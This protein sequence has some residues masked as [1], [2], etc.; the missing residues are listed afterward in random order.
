[1]EEYPMLVDPL[2]TD[3]W[4]L[5][6]D[7]VASIPTLWLECQWG[8]VG[9]MESG[10]QQQLQCVRVRNGWMC[11][12]VYVECVPVPIVITCSDLSSPTYGD[13]DYGG[14]STNSRPVDTVA[15]YT[16]NTGYTLIGGST[17]TCGSD[18]V[19]SGFPPF[20]QRKWNGLC[21]VCLL[22][23][24]SPI[25]VSALTYPH[26][27]MGWLCTVMDPLTTDLS[28]LELPTAATLATLS[29]EVPPGSVGL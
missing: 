23:V 26:W 25:Q 4:V 15:T 2:T 20:C 10:A 27:P 3:Q 12:N 5:Q 17:R 8:L 9:V 14:G 6:P 7:T 16:C 11:N 28:T 29:L 1:M 13:I 18:G 22:S 21:T 19:W 24:S